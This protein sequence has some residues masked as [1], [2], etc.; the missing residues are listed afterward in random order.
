MHVPTCAAVR[1][2]DA[3][4]NVL[5]LLVLVFVKILTLESALLRLFRFQPHEKKGPLDGCNETVRN[6]PCMILGVLS[7]LQ[8]GTSFTNM[9]QNCKP[10][11]KK[12]A[13]S[14]RVIQS[15][16]QKGFRSA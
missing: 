3:L 11:T 9:S 1:D 16:K 12:L 7:K 13:H 6:S 5:R 8:G 10:N 14:A 15:P 4:H 2:P